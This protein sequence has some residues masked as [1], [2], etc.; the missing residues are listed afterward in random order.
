MKNI[1][2]QITLDKIKEEISN[3]LKKRGIHVELTLSQ[4]LEKRNSGIKIS[5]TEFTT[6]PTLYKKC[7]I[8]DFGTSLKIDEDREDDKEVLKLWICVNAS[9]EYFSLG[10]NGVEL[11]SFTCNVYQDDLHSIRIS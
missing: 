8:V 9:F 4:Y 5:S 3:Q 7:T 11:F 10:S 6:T 2:S 1:L